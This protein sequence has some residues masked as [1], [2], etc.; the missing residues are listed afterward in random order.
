MGGRGN[1]SRI[2]TLSGCLNGDKEADPEHIDW[3]IYD[4][5]RSNVMQDFIIAPQNQE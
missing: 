1:N 2:S 3:W 4:G 5:K